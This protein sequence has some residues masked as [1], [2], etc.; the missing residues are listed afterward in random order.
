MCHSNCHGFIIS[1]CCRRPRSKQFALRPSTSLKVLDSTDSHMLLLQTH[2]MPQGGNYETTAGHS[3]RT[4]ADSI[5]SGFFCCG[6]RY[7]IYLWCVFCITCVKNHEISIISK[8]CPFE[9]FQGLRIQ[10]PPMAKLSARLACSSEYILGH[11]V[12]RQPRSYFGLV[13][14][15]IYLVCRASPLENTYIA[16]LRAISKVFPVLFYEYIELST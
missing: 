10:F 13:D 4:L 9:A 8:D 3:N 15:L 6:K 7:N 1:K 12:P 16:G 14:T 11:S 5:G 2:S